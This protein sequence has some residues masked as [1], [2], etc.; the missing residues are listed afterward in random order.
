MSE[1]FGP[2]NNSQIIDLNANDQSIYTPAYAIYEGVSQLFESILFCWRFYE[3]GSISKVALFNYVTD[4]SGANTYTATISVGG[5]QTGAANATPAQVKV[6]WVLHSLWFEWE[7]QY[8]TVLVNFFQRYFAASS[9]SEKYNLTWAGQVS[10]LSPSTYL[11]TAQSNLHQ[12]LWCHFRVRWALDGRF[13][14]QDCY[15][16]PNR[17]YLQSTSSRPRF[18]ARLPHRQRTFRDHPSRT[19]DLPDHSS[20]KTS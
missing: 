8:L 16:R 2:N 14:C 17:Q 12:D 1:A 18:R 11:P 6:K 9:V 3:G 13:G 7:Y 5:G 4:A 20:N 19:N 15:M 10:F